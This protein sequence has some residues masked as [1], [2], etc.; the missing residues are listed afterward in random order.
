[1]LVE[2][3]GGGGCSTSGY[4]K[5]SNYYRDSG[6]RSGSGNNCN[7]SKPSVVCLPQPDDNP[8]TTKD[9]PWEYSAEINM[10]IHLGPPS[11][12][13]IPDYYSDNLNDPAICS[14]A[15]AACVPDLLLRFPFSYGPEKTENNFFVA[16]TVNWSDA[17]GIKMSDIQYTNLYGGLVKVDSIKVNHEVFAGSNGYLPINGL[18]TSIS[19]TGG[20]FNG[21]Y[22]M[23]VRVDGR[24]WIKTPNGLSALP[25]NLNIVLPTVA[26]FKHVLQ[27]GQLLYKPPGIP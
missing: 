20:S 25:F 7:G 5:P 14:A 4:C 10:G 17:N 9:E 27:T 12:A 15:P 16:F 26:E 19:G 3:E 18:S 2:N 11:D 13:N 23:P 6:R 24:T 1:M 21:S 22:P 8:D